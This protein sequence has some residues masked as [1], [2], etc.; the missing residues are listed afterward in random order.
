MAKEDPVSSVHR[1]ALKKTCA[2]CHPAEAGR[3][4]YL[5]WFAS[6]Q[7][8]SH[9]KQDFSK[10]YGLGNCLGCHQGA[11]AHGEEK[12]INDQDCYKCHN[13]LMG[14]M[15]P[16]A[17]SPKQPGVLVSAWIHQVFLAGLL[18]GGFR[19]FIRKRR[20]KRRGPR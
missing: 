7:I 9:G 6:L 5:S 1:D 18:W 3:L 13:V 12:A 15:H 8:V 17:E 10:P 2:T 20:H 16:K 4:S 19:F 11:G 14:Y